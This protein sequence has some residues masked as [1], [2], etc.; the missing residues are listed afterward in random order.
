MHYLLLLGANGEAKVVAGIR[1]L[2]RICRRCI[3]CQLQTQHALRASSS[4]KRDSVMVSNLNF[5]FCFE[6]SDMS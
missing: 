2:A 1:E 6:P 5:R 3:T 4:A